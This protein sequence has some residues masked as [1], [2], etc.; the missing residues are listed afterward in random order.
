MVTTEEQLRVWE[1]NNPPWK[2][3]DGSK[4][5]PV[6]INNINN[7]NKSNVI[8]NVVIIIFI[9]IAL[10]FLSLAGFRTYYYEYFRDIVDIN[11]N[12]TNDCNPITNIEATKWSDVECGNVSVN[13]NC[14]NTT[15]MQM[16]LEIVCSDNDMFINSTM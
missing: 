8:K 7:I 6:N 12:N 16:L 2:M 4:F 15:D 10:S 9:F 1:N 3:I 13:C 11:N 14:I 5:K